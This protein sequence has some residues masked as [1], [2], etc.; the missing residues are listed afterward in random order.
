MSTLKTAQSPLKHLRLDFGIWGGD[1]VS[2]FGFGG[3]AKGASEVVEP[4]PA[5]SSPLFPFR[6]PTDAELPRGIYLSAAAERF[7]AQAGGWVPAK[8]CRYDKD[9]C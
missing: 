7:P 1:R 4:A 2:R 5:P 8:G 9:R 6:I 3:V